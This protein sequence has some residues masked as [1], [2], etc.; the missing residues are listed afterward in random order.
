MS[1]ANDAAAFDLRVRRHIYDQLIEHTNMPLAAEIASGLAVSVDRVREA[2]QR[3]KA[4][5]VLVLQENDLEILMANP[6]SAVPTPFEVRTGGKL[7][8]GKCIWDALGIAA[9]V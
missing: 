1:G 2:F 7:W 4:A 9:M 6:F 3:M 5:H 8:W